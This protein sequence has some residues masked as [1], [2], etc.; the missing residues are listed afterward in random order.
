MDLGSDLV[1]GTPL[2]TV[3]GRDDWRLVLELTANRGDM[4][5]HIGV[6]R[7]LQPVAGCKLVRPVSDPQESGPDIHTLASV[8]IEDTEGCPRYMARVIES[9]KVGPSP[10]WLVQRLEAIGQRSI[11]NVVDVTNFIMFELGQPLHSFDLD[12]LEENRIIVRKAVQDE[13]ILTLDGVMRSL[14]ARMT[15]IA[16]ASKP[17]AVAGVMGDKLTEVGDETSRILLECAYFDP[18][19]NR[20]SSR[21]LGLPSEASRR[22]ERG[23]D[24]ESMPYALDRAARLIAEVSGGRVARGAIDVY[25]RRIP[26][27]VVGL[28]AFRAKK[29]LGLEFTQA[30]IR[31]LS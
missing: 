3:L 26:P 7:D 4:W 13:N 18:P 24:Y 12:R 20:R 8:T 9:V 30:E 5:S 11:N 23:V 10:R 6:A 28:R 2:A 1:P 17:V 31:S 27:K 15:V 19:T 25:P 29:I 22:F 14:D 21:K 16:D